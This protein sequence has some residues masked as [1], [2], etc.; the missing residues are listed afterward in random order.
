MSG[1]GSTNFGPVALSCE[2]LTASC[3]T[4]YS[5]WSPACPELPTTAWGLAEGGGAGAERGRTL[6]PALSGRPLQA[7]SRTGGAARS[8]LSADGSPWGPLAQTPTGHSHGPPGF[9]LTPPGADQE[10]GGG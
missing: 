2:S 5:P 7:V 8:G 10:H 9:A 6:S 4:E 3:R 1:M